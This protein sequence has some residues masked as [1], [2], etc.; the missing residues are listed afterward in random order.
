M[1]LVERRGI[2]RNTTSILENDVISVT[3]HER[4]GR[5]FDIF[6]IQGNLKD[7]TQFITSEGSCSK[8]KQHLKR[9]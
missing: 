6:G 9:T 3:V 7:L 4:H 1:L 8:F 2:E 5:V